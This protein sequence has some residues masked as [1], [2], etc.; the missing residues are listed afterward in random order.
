MKNFLY[1]SIL[2]LNAQVFAQSLSKNSRGSSFNPAIGLNA[3]TLYKNS[4]RDNHEDGFQLQ[5]AELQFSADVDAYFR[6][7]A[8]IGIHKE[9]HEDDAAEEE[10]GYVV[11]PEEIFVET[12]SIPAVTIKAGKFYTQFGKYNMV[13]THAQPFIYRGVVQEYMFGHEGLSE[14]GVSL[15]YLAP[16]PWFSDITVQ[17]L[18]PTNE[19]LFEECHHCIATVANVK[20]LWDLSDSL[21]LEWGLSGLYADNE[22]HDSGLDEK[23]TVL[24]SDLTFKWRPV[25]NGKD[26]SFIWSTEFIHRNLEGTKDEKNGGVSSFIRYQLS[27]R[28]YASAQ[29]EFL[30]LG[31]DENLADQNVYT[32]ALSFVPTEFSAVR[33][34]YDQIHDGE[35][36]EER[37]V[38]MQLSFSIGAHPA[39]VY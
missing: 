35:E 32:G 16:L 17:V 26:A 36:R 21:T 25:K 6:A 30:G 33:L 8:T 10:H 38:S 19:E 34:Q 14:V 22:N 27:Q 37:R 11:E 39:H 15:S 9:H 18:Q 23:V 28:W 13:H 1:I 20:N 7:E 29:Y 31:K 24:G 4:S 2:L 12:I 3:L 5:E